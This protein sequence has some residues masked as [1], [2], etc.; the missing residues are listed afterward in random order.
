MQLEDARILVGIGELKVLK[1]T[2]GFI[3]THALGSCI[4]I[5]IYDATAK[6]GGMLHAQLPAAATNPARAQNEPAVFV[7]LG[8]P[9]LFKTAMSLGAE[10]RRLRVAVAGG[11]AV[12]AC[13]TD[14]F[15]IGARNLTVMR[16]LFWMNGVLIKGEDSGG[17]KPRTMALDLTTGETWIESEGKRYG[18]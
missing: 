16:K 18:I 1:D 4:G 2:R 6:V 10:K 5:T 12:G 14:L 15:Q 3:I 11:A 8:V 13:A 17:T 7:D 9:L